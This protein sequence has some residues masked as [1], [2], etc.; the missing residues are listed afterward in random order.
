MEG[1]SILGKEAGEG[2]TPR[3]VNIRRKTPKK[4][5][6]RRQSSQKAT[7]VAWEAGPGSAA[8]RQ[9]PRRMKY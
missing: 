5:H 2:K 9:N 6:I 8:G 3:R 4:R 7:M 1:A